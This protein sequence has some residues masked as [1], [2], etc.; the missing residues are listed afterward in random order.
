[1]NRDL[2]HLGLEN[3]AL[4][5][6]DIADIPLLEEAVL[7]LAE[8]VELGENLNLACLIVQ[9]E[10]RNLA[11]AA[12]RHDSAG[13]ADVL[14]LIFLKLLFNCGGI[15]IAVAR[16]DDKGISAGFSERLELFV[17]NLDNVACVCLLWLV[18]HIS[19][20][21]LSNFENLDADNAAGC[22]NLDNVAD[23]LVHQRSADGAFVGD[24]TLLG[25]GF[26]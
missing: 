2:A 25:V 20:S 10:E 6:Y 5:L 7:L 15:N 23:A 26:I 8:V 14:V 1:M 17:A 12:L 4:D 11:L 22:F 16:G 9:I 13:N 24:F 21:L 3:K 19:T 18:T